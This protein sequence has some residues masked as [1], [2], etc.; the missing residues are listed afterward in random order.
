MLAQVHNQ[1]SG[2]SAERTD[3][4]TSDHGTDEI[5]FISIL[6][7]REKYNIVAGD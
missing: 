4:I 1:G 5:V 6:A 7:F 2:S 3:T